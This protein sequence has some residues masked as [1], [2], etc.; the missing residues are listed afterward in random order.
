M[1]GGQRPHGLPA[2]AQRGGQGAG[3]GADRGADGAGQQQGLGDIREHGLHLL[4]Q[5]LPEPGSQSAAVQ[6][7]LQAL[8]RVLV[9]PVPLQGDVEGGQRPAQVRGKGE[10]QGQDDALEVGAGRPGEVDADRQQCRAGG[11]GGFAPSG[12]ASPGS[13]EGGFQGAREGGLADP[14][15]P[16]EH[17]DV[18]ARGLQ[19]LDVD[20]GG[21]DAGQVLGER[22]L[23]QLPLPLAVREG[24]RGLQPS[25]VRTEQRPQ[26]PPV[27]RHRIPQ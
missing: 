10:A 14:A 11:P 18:A 16:V 1:A 2:F 4:R 26:V 19:V 6:V 5:S 7:L 9:L 27:A 15:D 21:R 12:R 20:G 3:E 17:Q 24:L 8:A 23:D 22:A 13:G 25:V